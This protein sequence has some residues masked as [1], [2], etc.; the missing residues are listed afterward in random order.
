MILVK[1]DLFGVIMSLFSLSL[2][3]SL[4]QRNTHTHT[5]NVHV[6]KVFTGLWADKFLSVLLRFSAEP[7]ES[8]F[9]VSFAWERKTRGFDLL[10]SEPI[11]RPASLFHVPLPHARKDTHDGSLGRFILKPLLQM[12]DW[13][14]ENEKERKKMT[15]WDKHVSLSLKMP[16]KV[17][18]PHL[19]WILFFSIRC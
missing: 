8:Y 12:R 16:V 11:C 10:L 5:Q 18:Y 19:R 2:T 15:S 14:K 6:L 7:A 4:S 9:S 17:I 13:R 1:Q 3:L